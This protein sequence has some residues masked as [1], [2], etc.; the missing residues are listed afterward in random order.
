MSLECK[1]VFHVVKKQSSPALSYQKVWD[2]SSEGVVLLHWQLKTKL[3]LNYVF[4]Y[5][6]IFEVIYSSMALEKESNGHDN[7][8]FDVSMTFDSRHTPVISVVL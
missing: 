3:K 5:F 6:I 8:A 4:F 7:V 1:Y 2:K